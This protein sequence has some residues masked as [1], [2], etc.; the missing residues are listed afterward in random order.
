MF[1]S[2]CFICKIETIPIWAYTLNPQAEREEF[3]D[4]CHK[5]TEKYLNKAEDIA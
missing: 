2:L 3:I 4:I 1:F 5:N